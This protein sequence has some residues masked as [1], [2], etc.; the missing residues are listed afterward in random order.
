V[1]AQSTGAFV[2]PLILAVCIMAVAA[3]TMIAFFHVRPLNE[4][5]AIPPVAAKA[6]AKSTAA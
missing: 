6:T 1:I 3:I 4:L 5:V 2:A